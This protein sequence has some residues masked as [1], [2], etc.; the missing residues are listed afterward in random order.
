MRY[1][2]TKASVVLLSL[3]QV[4]Y[5][6][7]RAD[8]L[9]EL[10]L[11]DLLNVRVVSG[12]RREQRQIN[13]PRSMSVITA[14][15]LRRRNYRTIPDALNSL[16]GVMTQYTNYGGGSPIIRGLIGNRILILIDGIR[17][18]NAIYR[19]GPNQ[20]L[21]TIDI[22]RVERIEVVRG[23]GSV[24]YG[25]DALGGL[26]NIIT[27]KPESRAGGGGSPEFHA[28]LGARLSSEDRGVS[29]R[30]QLEAGAGRWS[31]TGGV[32]L[33][34]F[35]D[36]RAGGP[37]GRQLNTGY[38]EAS[39]D[40]KVNYS[41]APGREF[42]ASVEHL[43]Q[44]DVRRTDVL[45]AG[46]SDLRYDWSPQLRQMLLLQY[47]HGQ[48]GPFIDE[49]QVSFTSQ[50]HLENINQIPAS[51]PTS[52]RMYD[53]R[54]RTEGL[55]LQITS[56]RGER[57][58]FTY[59]LDYYVDRVSSA[60]NDLNLLSRG[61]TAAKSRF[62]DGSRF[63]SVGA[64]LQ[65][66]IQL[67]PD[68]TVNLR[69]RYSRFDLHATISDAATGTVAIDNEPAALTAGAYVSRRLK[70][71]LF[72][73]GGVG[74]GFRAPNVD[75]ATIVGSFASGFEVPNASLQPEH[76]TNYEA[77]LKYQSKR[78]SG[79]ASAYWSRFDNLIDRGPGSY[80]GL[81]YLDLNGNRI[82]DRGEEAIFQ[83]MNMGRAR[84]AGTEL[85][86]HV[87]LTRAWS[88]WANASWIHGVDTLQQAPL[89]RIPPA[90]GET[91]LRWQTQ[92]HIWL[93]PW[94]FYA[95]RQT[96]LSSADRADPRIARNGTPGFALA[97]IRAG[98]PL[99]GIGVLTLQFG[100]LANKAYRQHGSGIDGAGRSVDIG[101]TRSF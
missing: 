72:L 74:Q 5:A 82:R 86:G 67:N 24:L 101:L 99:G 19:L 52:L 22:N 90:K 9:A 7:S 57:H 75:D 84:I 16:A 70:P 1:L 35:G 39:G 62:A 42:T 92:R 26:I 23:P 63:R 34:R 29:S 79:T 21:N 53:D 58:V 17:I 44:E 87:Q 20:Y 48:T 96:R 15:E 56:H 55:V 47:K 60:R 78:L 69:A 73:V 100:N 18:N 89:T 54:V 3:S 32:S 93:E 68:L 10:N 49:W 91:G 97:G 81:P 31:M 33:K 85:D 83:R 61:V 30:A 4:G 59:G 27:K 46:A 88:A 66:E 76:A 6:Q 71:G 64:F 25:S 28:G 98:V 45:R 51:R 50:R 38:D 36:L 43:Q 8:N 37:V 13:S 40:M 95:W 11:D 77:G 65:D 80:L 2:L 12:T 41:L 94:L 14:E